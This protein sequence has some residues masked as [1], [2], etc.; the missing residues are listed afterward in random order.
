MR[1]LNKLQP[2]ALFLLRL[3]VGVAMVYHSYGKVY[4]AEGFHSGHY[5]AALEHF[6][7]F[8]VTLGL[9]RWLGDISTVTEFVGGTSLIF[10]LLTRFW[11]FLITGNMLIALITVNYHGG[12][13]GSEYTLALIAMSLM[14]VSA[15]S[16]SLSLDRKFGFS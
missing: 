15:G 3:T 5:L 6:N 9:P 2:W 8:V 10:G 11:A 7:D 4:S 1:T 16:G 14:L 12:Y 13:R